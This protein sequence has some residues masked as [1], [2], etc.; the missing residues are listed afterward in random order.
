MPNINIQRTAEVMLS[1][2]IVILAAADLGVSSDGW[3][4]MKKITHYILVVL[5]LTFASAAHS[6]SPAIKAALIDFSDFHKA[7]NNVYFGSDLSETEQRDMQTLLDTAKDRITKT[8][9]EPIAKPTIIVTSSEKTA[10]EYGIHDVPAKFFFAPWGNYLII[11]QNHLDIDV[12]AHELVHAEIAERLGYTARYWRFSTWL[13]E[14]AALQVDY[15]SHYMF[16]CASFDK[17]EIRRVKELDSPSRFWSA[18][19]DQN[20]KNYQ[21]AK[22][23]VCELFKQVPHS[24]LYGYLERIRQGE[25]FHDVFGIKN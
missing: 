14:G 15:R 3:W 6:C 8:F 4:Q 23:A 11:N 9:G 2:R 1:E 7:G 16:D 22:A 24:S 21:A 20:I 18:D 17:S 13:D 10:G 5:F 19:K 25:N 12:I